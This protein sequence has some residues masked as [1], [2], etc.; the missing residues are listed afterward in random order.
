[1]A[2]ELFAHISL[3]THAYNVAPVLNDIIEE[4]LHHVDEEEHR[5][6]GDEEPQIF[7]GN[8]IVDDILGDNGIK[9][10]AAGDDEGAGHVQNKQTQMRFSIW[11]IFLS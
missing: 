3:N 8:V 6:P 10:V 4:S 1:M 2:K 9:Q 11:Q 7:I 5:G